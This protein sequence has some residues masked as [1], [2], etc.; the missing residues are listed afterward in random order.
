MFQT[1]NWV[2]LVLFLASSPLL[3]GCMSS[4]KSHK[5]NVEILR[6]RPIAVD[7]HHAETVLTVDVEVSYH[8]CPGEQRSFVRG[9]KEFA[10]C[11]MKHSVGEKVPAKIWWGPN[12]ERTQ[13]VSKIMGLADCDRTPDPKDEASYEIVQ[14]CEDMVVNGVVVGVHCDRR[15]NKELLATCPWF[16]IR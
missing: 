10:S 2:A 12:T 4:P 8:E 15:R 3:V 9:D 13:Y 1:S 7:E 16:R 14:D 11:I 6:I 5:T